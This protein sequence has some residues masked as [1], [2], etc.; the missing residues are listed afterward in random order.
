MADQ[1]LI[2]SIVPNEALGI[3]RKPSIVKISLVAAFLVA[4]AFIGYSLVLKTKPEDK[5][6]PLDIGKPSQTTAI[7]P[8]TSEPVVTGQPAVTNTQVTPDASAAVLG[9]TAPVAQMQTPTQVPVATPQPQSTATTTMQQINTAAPAVQQTIPTTQNIQV[10]QP[11]VNSQVVV[12]QP[13]PDQKLTNVEKVVSDSELK[14]LIKV[15]KKKKSVKRATPK[16][17]NEA[18]AVEH[19]PAAPVIEEGVTQ[20]E[21]IVF[22]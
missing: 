18:K 22:Q 14:K 7:T 12:Q 21:I 16:S 9:N 10:V 15:E 4:A 5:N 20:E 6:P 3:K 13:I 11:T 1:E 2:D 19:T 8:A 17:T